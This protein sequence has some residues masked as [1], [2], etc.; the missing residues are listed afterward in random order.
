MESRTLHLA[1]EFDLDT[2]RLRILHFDDAA[3][4]ERARY[5][6]DPVSRTIIRKA[7]GDIRD[8]MPFTYPAEFRRQGGSSP[9]VR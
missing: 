5:S 9:D 8:G 4:P 3:M 7:N 1:G 6:V 2:E